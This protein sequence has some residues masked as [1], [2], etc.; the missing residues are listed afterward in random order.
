MDLIRWL[1]EYAEQKAT[2]ENSLPPKCNRY[3]L[4]QLHY[5]IGLCGEAG[6]F[7]TTDISFGEEKFKR[8]EIGSLTWSGHEAL[9]KLRGSAQ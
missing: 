7:T 8:Y 1:L 3:T 6:Y 4:E 9:D 5:H 2:T